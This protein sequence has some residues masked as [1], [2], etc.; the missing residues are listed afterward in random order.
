MN[1]L[2]N[3]DWDEPRRTTTT[4]KQDAFANLLQLNSRPAPEPVLSLAEQQRRQ[5]QTHRSET[6]SSPW[7]TPTQSAIP[8]PT[9]PPL[10]PKPLL[11]SNSP[12]PSSSFDSLLDPFARPSKQKQD[13]SNTPLNALR[14][15]S[16]KA[17]AAEQ[18]GQQWNFDLFDKDLQKNS[19]KEN[20]GSDPFDMDF[21]S[22]GSATAVC[23]ESFSLQDDDNP[24]GILA[25][26]AVQKR[27]VAI[28]QS[29]SFEPISDNELP[30]Y[31]D[32][33]DEQD[34]QD[35]LLAQLIDM[36]FGPDVS[37]EAIK[38]SG[39]SDLQ[40]AIALLVTDA[41][42]RQQSTRTP[43]SS[44]PNYSDAEQ[45]RQKI[46]ANEDVQPSPARRAA[47]ETKRPAHREVESQ[48]PDAFQ[49]HTERL[50]AQA[51]EIG[52]FLFKNASMFVKTGREKIT[53]AVDTWQEQQKG[54][55]PTDP[56]GPVRPRWMT[57][58]TD[59]SVERGF[60]EKPLEKFVDEADSDD[61]N[62]NGQPLR[63]TRAEME[64]LERE[65]NWIRQQDLQRREDMERRKKV[66]EQQQKDKQRQL[67]DDQSTYVSPSRRR[68]APR[69]SP[70]QQEAPKPAPTQRSAPPQPVKR[71][72]TR[73]VVQ[74]T[75]QAIEKAN[76]SR[77][78]GNELFKLGQFGD[79]A[80]A[81]TQAIDALPNGH[82][83]LVL[84]SNNRAAARLKIGEHKGCVQDCSLVI[85]MAQ[86]VGDDTSTESEG[87]TI[88]WKEQTV[89]ALNR[90]AE[91]FENLEKYQDALN[92]YQDL[93]KLEGNGNQ[94][95]NQGMA[96]CRKALAPV[97]QRQNIEKKKPSVPAPRLDVGDSKA[98][99]DMR[100]RA[101]QQ[102]ADDAERLEK[103][104]EVNEK[105]LGWKAGKEQNLRAL[106]ATID[107]LLWPGAQWKG[108]QMSELINP[109]KCKMIYLRAISK[110][111]PDKLPSTVTIE[112]RMLASAIFSTLNEA[113]D[114]FRQTNPV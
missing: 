63:Q 23:P 77:Q 35:E 11:P 29:L 54:H 44:T 76:Q 66:Q 87:M 8:S 42:V 13:N 109:K 64:R 69:A 97:P 16:L 51:S 19:P 40:S 18:T 22:S 82:D 113:W 74:A 78:K 55:N 38:A 60:D 62:Q 94:Q 1:N 31:H 100:A 6:T 90:M 111:H 3:L 88:R 71:V 85:E 5:A 17:V 104:D 43:R 59:D 110:V 101:A 37:L 98:V 14:A 26:P 27:S 75:P 15:T 45:A 32:G 30:Q 68:P 12:T 93:C 7:L 50:V 106:L 34:G 10:S 49:Q 83:H 112:Q 70:R 73:P 4:P 96:R 41:E 52:G 108:A 86:Q 47:R 20:V 58:V 81:Y 33:P 65:K 21:L 25:E 114:C 79:A 39:G 105:I 48:H 2:V 46:F 107:T 28:E 72:R 92:T 99:A 57:D 84:L 89:K 103:T 36:G 95:T 61:E 102:E 53:K 91:A 56:G 67:V 80:Y 9:Q 24:L